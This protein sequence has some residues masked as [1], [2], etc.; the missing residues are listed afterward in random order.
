MQGMGFATEVIANPREGRGPAFVATRIEDPALPTVLVYGHGDVVRGL[1]G[2]WSDGLDPWQVTVRGERW[3]GRGTVDNK[4]QHLIAVEALRAAMAERGGTLGFNAK[5][6]VETGE[7]QGSPGLRE[8]L[9]QHRA[10]L[11]ADVFIGLDG[12]RQATFMPEMRL[13]ARGGVAFDMVV[14]LRDHAHHSGHWGGVLKDPAFRLAHALASIVTPEGRILVEG[15]TPREI[16]PAVRRA[17]AGLVF[18]EVPGLPPEDAG[19]GEPG[20]TKGEKIFGWTSVIVLAQVTGHPDAPTNAVQGEARARLQVR[21][22]AD[23]AGAGIVPALRRHLDAR[24]F[25]DVTVVP[26]MERDMF[27]AARTDPDDPWVAAVAASMAATAGRAPNVVPNS[28]GSNPSDMFLEELGIPVIWIPNSY[29]GCNQHGPDEH[30]LA[31]LLRE[32]MRLMAGLWWDI[33][34]GAAP[35]RGKGTD[36]A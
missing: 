29:A 1:A 16:P 15:W 13:G 36:H 17:I 11:A 20:L 7:E 10:A 32:G 18:E 34:A 30:A 3:Y 14:H 33:G 31:P 5:V 8:V 25:G 9:R 22:T 12:P 28:S 2:R 35:R 23:V 21:H 6:L 27:G 19:W 24:G 4:G 26:V